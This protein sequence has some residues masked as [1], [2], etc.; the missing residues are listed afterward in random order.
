MKKKTI[1][2][3]IL[4]AF[5]FMGCKEK[6]QLNREAELEGIEQTRQAF[7]K[8][9]KEGDGEMMGKL[10]TPDIVVIIPGS[11]DWVNMYRMNTKQSPFPYDSIV[12]SPKETV[13]ASDSLAYDFGVSTVY[14]TDSTGVVVELKDTFLAILKKGEDGTWKLHR[15]VASST[16]S[17]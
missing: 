11:S 14:Y 2:I 4:T 13:L 3:L 17:D 5:S 9:V 8:A 16:I 7:I 10:T 1:Y 6:P 12:M 15:E